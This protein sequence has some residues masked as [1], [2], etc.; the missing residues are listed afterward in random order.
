MQR[1]N[2]IYHGNTNPYFNLSMEEYLLTKKTDSFICLWKNS[3]SVIVGV[4][5]NTL[6]EVNLAF[7]QKN[8]IKVIRRQT[9]GGAVYHDLNNICYTVIA[10]FEHSE[11][12]YIKFASPI[13]EYL[14]TLGV[15]A[16]FS[17]RNDILIE[18][19]KISGNAQKIV[20]NRII[21]H[22]TLMFN[23]DVDM[24]TNSL[25]VN[26][27]KI[28]SKGIKSVKSRVTNISNYV[29]IDAT[30]FFNGL[31]EFVKK[32]CIPYTLTE[33]DIKGI[34]QLIES[35][36]SKDLWNIGYSPKG[37]NSFSY[38]FNFGLLNLNF[39]SVEGK[40]F[41]LNI[42]GDFFTN[43]D[44]KEFSKS[45]EGVQFNYKSLLLAFERISDYIVGANGKEI[46]DKLF[47][48]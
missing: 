2:F 4:N 26:K 30:T 6:E 29:D 16:E 38:K 42:Y 47:D 19:K 13:I 44:I 46:I 36:Y 3:P 23:T 43:R 33:E 32:D 11:N 17:G 9:G 12:S 1:F 31:V 8:D 20:G 34:N 5:Q 15:N 35:K 7:T 18:G 40:I 48:E 41:N 21:Q 28:Q 45:L 37:K 25:K 14:K 22:G 10:P 24:L 27:L 39:D